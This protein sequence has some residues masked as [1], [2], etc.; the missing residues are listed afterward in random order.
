MLADWVSALWVHLRAQLVRAHFIDFWV[1][2]RVDGALWVCLWIFLDCTLFARGGLD[3]LGV[4]CALQKARNL[5]AVIVGLIK[6]TRDLCAPHHARNMFMFMPLAP[7]APLEKTTDRAQA[8]S[9]HTSTEKMVCQQRRVCRVSHKV[10][11]R[12]CLCA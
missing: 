11:T 12:V 7:H 8:F 6:H 10:R 3:A 4:L 9:R 2:A 1:R 5:S